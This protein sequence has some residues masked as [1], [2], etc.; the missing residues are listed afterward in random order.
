MAFGPCSL[1]KYSSIIPSSQRARR[2]LK[3]GATCRRPPCGWMALYFVGPPWHE[4]RAYAQS[5]S[6]QPQRPFA[7]ETSSPLQ[8]LPLTF[9]C[10]GLFTSPSVG[11]QPFLII[12]PHSTCLSSVFPASVGAW[13]NRNLLCRFLRCVPVLEENSLS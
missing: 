3:A 9:P 7:L 8:G 13:G 1:V 11:S 6:L 2:L 12:Y 10:L 5:P 4:N